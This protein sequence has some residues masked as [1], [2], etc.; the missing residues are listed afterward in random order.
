M[1]STET[2]D[3]RLQRAREL[4]TRGYNCAQAVAMVFEDV[5]GI[6][7]DSMAQCCMALGSGAACG[8]IC[9]AALGMGIITG[10]R[11]DHDPANK[12]SAA[13][14]SRSLI[15]KFADLHNGRIRCA[16][17]KGQ[18]GSPSC[19]QLVMTAVEILHNDIS[20]FD[21]SR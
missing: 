11:F 13:K 3:S 4:R 21:S 8:E 18:P 9:G 1:H 17:L 12:I 6:S 19:D 14:A 16:D 15:S 7:A 5:S 20:G 10:Y 2:L